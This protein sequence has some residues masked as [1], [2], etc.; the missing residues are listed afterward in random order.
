VATSTSQF[1]LYPVVFKQSHGKGKKGVALKWPLPDSP[2]EKIDQEDAMKNEAES[3]DR[4][5]ES[6]CYKT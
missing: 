4:E 2:L 6:M 1:E 5:A 3:Y